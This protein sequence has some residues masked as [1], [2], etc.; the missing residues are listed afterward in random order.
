MNTHNLLLRSRLT[1][2]KD[3]FYENQVVSVTKKTLLE[4]FILLLQLS[5]GC[6]A[7]TVEYPTICYTITKFNKTILYFIFFIFNMILNWN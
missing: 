1:C 5:E 4:V 2:R 3:M 6:S 7:E